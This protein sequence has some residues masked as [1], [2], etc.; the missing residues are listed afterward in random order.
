LR[1]LTYGNAKGPLKTG[2]PLHPLVLLFPAMF[3]SLASNSSPQF[4]TAEYAGRPGSDHCK[5]CGQPIAGTYYRVGGDIACPSCAQ[6]AQSALPV[7]KHSAYARALIFGVGGAI[8]GIIIYATFG[9]VTGLVIGYLSLAVGYIVGKAMMM[10]SKGIGGRRYQITAVLLTYAAVSMAAVPIA[11]S[12]YIKQKS[13]LQAEQR[14]FQNDPSLHNPP[15]QTNVGGDQ[16]APA[17]PP[18]PSSILVVLASLAWLGLTSPFLELQDP[19]H[20]AIGLIILF[21]GIRIAWQSTAGSPVA[22]VSGP[23]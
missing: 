15:G 22:E 3:D 12:Q 5:L 11:I 2:C 9:I 8:L 14:S 4:E 13:N 21:V 18:Q 20:G 1:F 16:I 6:R 17:P 7:D 23:F 10:G 19:V